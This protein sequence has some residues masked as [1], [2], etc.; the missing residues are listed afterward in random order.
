MLAL[1][2]FESNSTGIGEIENPPGL[3]GIVAVAVIFT[4]FLVFRIWR[5]HQSSGG[6]WFALPALLA[7][8]WACNWFFQEAV[9][10]APIHVVVTGWFIAL[11]VMNYKLLR[12]GDP[13]GWTRRRCQSAALAVIM[14]FPVL[15][16]AMWIYSDSNAYQLPASFPDATRDQLRMIRRI[17][18]FLQ[19]DTYAA[20]A[21]AAQPAMGLTTATLLRNGEEMIPDSIRKDGTFQG[22]RYKVNL[23]TPQPGL[24]TVDVVP[25]SYEKGR[26]SFHVFPAYP[27][28]GGRWDYCATMVDNGGLPATANDPHFH[29]RGFLER[30]F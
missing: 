1:G 24:F 8:A 3:D 10:Y 27:S 15:L 22:Y 28:Y 6:G 20:V 14:W 7:S 13:S 17:T 2:H 26:P 4:A 9:M 16:S 30:Y 18:A 23:D 12:L 5:L 11:L 29:Q 25:I 21:T 19:G